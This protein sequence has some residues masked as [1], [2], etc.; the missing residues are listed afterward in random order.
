MFSHT[1]IWPLSH[2]WQ[3][4]LL[5]SPLSLSL[6]DWCSLVS[7]L[8]AGLLPLSRDYLSITGS[9]AVRSVSPASALNTLTTVQFYGSSRFPRV[10]TFSFQMPHMVLL[11]F[12]ISLRVSLSL[13]F[14]VC[15]VAIKRSDLVMRGNRTANKENLSYFSPF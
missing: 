10:V 7:A 6:S 4:T 12:L 8:Y 3:H 5:S 9:W 1:H 15:R 11:H 14:H 2:C 13:S